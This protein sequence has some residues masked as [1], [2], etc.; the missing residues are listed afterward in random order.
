MDRHGFIH[1]KLDIKILILYILRRL[2]KEV[3]FTKLTEFVM[4]DEGFDYFEYTQCLSELV[5]TDHVTKRENYYMITLKGEKHGITVESSI[6]YSV[7]L[8][9]ESIIE[10]TVEKMKRDGLIV[11]EHKTNNDGSCT[12]K[13]SLSDGVGEILNLNILS[14][15]QQQA[16]EMEKYF[17]AKA[18]EIYH[19]IIGIL[20]P[21]K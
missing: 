3:D 6:P 15:G 1:E 8:K 13:F 12:M 19:Q 17:R 9:A 4:I 21:E 7:R 5:E 20:T 10:P 18:E 14:S 16:L 11:T 2:P